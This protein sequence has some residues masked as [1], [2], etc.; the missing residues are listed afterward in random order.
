MRESPSKISTVRS[1]IWNE[2]D[3][4]TGVSPWTIALVTNSLAITWAASFTSSYVVQLVIA[5]LSCRYP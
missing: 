3:K 2:I 1:A 4:M 5:G